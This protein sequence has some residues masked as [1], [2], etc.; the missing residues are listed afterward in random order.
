VGKALR[1]DL[2]GLSSARRGEYRVLYRLNEAD[3][4][5]LVVRIS[6]RSHAYRPR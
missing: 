3:Q 1:G 2:E 5:I 4:S 6:H